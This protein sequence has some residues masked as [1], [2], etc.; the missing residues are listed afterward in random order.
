MKSKMG[1]EQPYD[2]MKDLVNGKP[3]SNVKYTTEPV[4]V[5]PRSKSIIKELIPDWLS[6][7]TKKK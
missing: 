3:I 7:S 5:K 4:I 1:D 6:K 2:P